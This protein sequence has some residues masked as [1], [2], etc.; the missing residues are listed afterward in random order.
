MLLKFSVNGS[1]AGKYIE[2]HKAWPQRGFD[3]GFFLLSG[4]LQEKSGGVI[5]SNKVSLSVLQEFVNEDPFVKWEKVNAEIIQITPNK[6]IP[7][8]AFLQN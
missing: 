7:E 5:I 3:N 4:S 1:G 2:D 8:L 6:F